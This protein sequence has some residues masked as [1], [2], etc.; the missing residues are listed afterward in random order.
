MVKLLLT[1]I[2]LSSLALMVTAH[3]GHEHIQTMAQMPL[4]GPSEIQVNLARP[5]LDKDIYTPSFSGISTFAH[6]PYEKCFEEETPDDYDIAV[7]GLPYDI[8]VTF[9]TGARFG[10]SGIREGS[11]RIKVNDKKERKKKEKEKGKCKM[12]RNKKLTFF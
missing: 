2:A 1:S 5:I 6:L 8:G 9:R 10:P 12:T 4:V 7:I 3:A 11:K